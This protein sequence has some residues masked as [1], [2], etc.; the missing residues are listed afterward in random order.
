VGPSRDRRPARAA[1]VGALAASVAALVV[2]V[3]LAARPATEVQSAAAA[4]PRSWA[5]PATLDI[6][7][8]GDTNLDAPGALRD[9]A[10]VL[11]RGDVTAVN[12]E[13]TYARSGVSKC[14]RSGAKAQC[15]AFAAPPGAAQALARAG[16][17][18]ANLA[19]NHAWDF[20]AAG[21]GDTVRALAA[22]GIDVTGRPGEIRLLLVRGRRVA[23]V[24][25][26]TYPWSA[27]MLVRADVRALIAAAAREADV[28]VACFHAGAEGIDHA[29]TP[30][31]G[32]H[33]LGEDRGDVRAFARIAIDA[34]ADLVL[35]SGPHVLRGME[36][37]RH[38]LIAYSL[39]N[40]AGGVFRTEGALGLSAVLR[41]RVTA[42]GRLAG[43]RLAPLRLDGAGVPHRDRSGAAL[44]VVNA[45][46]R[47]D[48]GARAVTF[49]A[50]GRLRVQGS[51]SRPASARRP[52]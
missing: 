13:G 15:F 11:R 12:N 4:S 23:F 7:W 50:A 5:L 18:V 6:S 17:D 2:V 10:T 35:G 51:S 24:G 43:G 22:Q 37:Y 9:V 32:E 21:M 26:S 49:T 8:A 39:G 31:A 33:Y 52:H 28:V 30:R 48:F 38:R 20:G 19:N 42:D 47:A 25:F 40:L 36:R 14:V 3:L 34:G 46:G 1:A 41:V 45:L 29:H 27:S 44:R 16:V